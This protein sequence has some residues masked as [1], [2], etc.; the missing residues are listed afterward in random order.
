MNISNFVKSLLCI[1]LGVGSLSTIRAEVPPTPLPTDSHL[2]VLKFN[3]SQIYTILTAPVFVT[4]IEFEVGEKLVMPPAMGDSIQWE[5]D[6]NENHLFIKPDAP[7]LRTNM[8]IVT[9]KR[10]YQF[11]LISSPEGG[12][13]YQNI[14]FKY[15][16]TTKKYGKFEPDLEV[17]KEPPKE[18]AP[19][20]LTVLDPSQ[21]NTNYKISGNGNFKPEFV[22]DDGKFTYMKFAN[23]VAELP[24]IYVKEN[25]GYS[26]VNYTHKPKNKFVTITLTSSEFVLILDNEKVFVSKKTGGFFQ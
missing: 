16:D 1:L 15:S 17:Q 5:V 26:V 2:A 8:V 6:T 10:S 23:D 25:G 12:F 19:T 7:S 21:L 3:A 11:V 20:N 18:S 14:K 13:Y 22:A 9:N 4:H 24:L